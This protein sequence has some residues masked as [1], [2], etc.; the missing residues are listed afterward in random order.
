MKKTI[1]YVALSALFA[2][3][4]Q[5]Q[6]AVIDMAA[7]GQLAA[8]ASTLGKQLTEA[9]NQVTQ[10]KNTYQSFTGSRDLGT[11]MNNPAL[12]NYLPQDWQKVYDSVKQ[13]GYAGL[14]GTA[15]TMYNQVF[16]SCKHITIDDERLSCEAAAVKG[17]QDK[18]FALDAYSK[19]QDR[20]DQIDQL[21]AKVNDTQDPK[22]IA[23][24]QAR[25]AT[26]Q[27]NIQ[28]EQ[29]KLQMYAMVASA[30]DKMQQ[31]N[32][33]EMNARTWSATKGISAQP[34][35]FNNP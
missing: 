35:T 20:M 21:M 26:E 8:Q 5:A 4:G 15:K 7:I 27:A 31:Q 10:L 32:K 2:S 6:E 24:L 13:G 12:R 28:N 30:E 11:I 19:A 9:K 25:I 1:L 3:T 34:I 17:A 18:G 16:D 23:E 22:A 29:T 33:R 14:S